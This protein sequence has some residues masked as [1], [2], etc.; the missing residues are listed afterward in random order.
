MR[1]IIFLLSLVLHTYDKF[2]FHNLPYESALSGICLQKHRYGKIIT[3]FSLSRKL[4]PEHL[5]RK[6]KTQPKTNRIKKRK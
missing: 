5:E 1:L 6:T 2:Y 4:N 3:N